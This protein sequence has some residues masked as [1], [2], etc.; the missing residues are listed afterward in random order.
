MCTRFDDQTSLHSGLEGSGDYD[1]DYEGSVGH[2]VDW[3]VVRGHGGK[4][5]RAGASDHVED[6][7][8]DN[9][10]PR[11][12]RC[13]QSAG[14]DWLITLPQT[15]GPTDA[16]LIPSYGGAHSKVI[17]EESERTPP[18]LECRSR[19]K[20]LEAII[21]L[22]DMSDEPYELLLA[23]PLGRLPYLVHQHIDSALIST[24]VERWQPDTNTFHMP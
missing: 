14:T 20:P 12:S 18:I 8:I 10:A 16:R 3:T 4:F 15:D 19:K 13:P 7:H 6:N 11:G 2:P 22:Q 9:A 1:T 24:F 17:F 5:T 23:I 21:K